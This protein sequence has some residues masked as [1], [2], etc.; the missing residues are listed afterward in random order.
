[1]MTEKIYTE[2][3]NRASSSTEGVQIQKGRR[4]GHRREPG[5]EHTKRDGGHRGEL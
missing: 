5:G 1:M 3:R 4:R 2:G